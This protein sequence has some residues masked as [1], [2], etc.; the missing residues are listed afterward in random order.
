MQR[1]TSYIS[2]MVTAVECVCEYYA[3][4][5]RT[6]LCGAAEVAVGILDQ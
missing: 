3:A 1:F 6:V 5:Y 4:E 2:H